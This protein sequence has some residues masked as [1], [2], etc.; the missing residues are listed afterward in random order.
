MGISWRMGT[1][2]GWKQIAANE[3]VG[4]SFK[5]KNGAWATT[6]Y[7][8]YPNAQQTFIDIKA[9]QGEWI[10]PLRQVIVELVGIGQQRFDNGTVNCLIFEKYI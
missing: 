2:A 7:Q 6:T 8:V 4:R 3:D 9:R 5:Y 1:V 10:P